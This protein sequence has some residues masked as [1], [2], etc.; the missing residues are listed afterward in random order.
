MRN[1]HHDWKTDITLRLCGAVSCGIS[2][3]AIDALLASRLADG[4]L[5]DGALPFI[6]AAAGF[7]CASVGSAL[8]ALGHHIFDEIQISRRWRTPSINDDFATADIVAQDTAGRCL[9]QEPSAL[10]ESRPA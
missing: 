1:W 6:L 2:Y 8:L 4:T 9:V 3:L 7:L 10:S 5:P